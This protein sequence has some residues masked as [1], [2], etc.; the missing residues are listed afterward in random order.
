MFL[1]N[2]L[3]TGVFKSGCG[4]TDLN[5]RG[6]GRGDIG[7]KEGKVADMGGGV[8]RMF[9]WCSSSHFSFS[10]F[11]RLSRSRTKDCCRAS[12]SLANVSC[13]VRNWAWKSEMV[14]WRDCS[15]AWDLRISF[16]R[17]RICN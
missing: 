13:W 17:W 8:K 10:S 4:D 6:G 1:L 3:R 15:E 5:C 14:A 12:F 2:V 7:G 11:I 9:S 16:S